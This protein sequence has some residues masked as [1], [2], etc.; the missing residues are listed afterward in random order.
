MRQKYQLITIK[1][2]SLAVFSLATM[3]PVF[4]ILPCGHIC[5][6]QYLLEFPIFRVLRHRTT[7]QE[8]GT[9]V[10]LVRR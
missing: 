3:I 4:L 8:H 10:N 2:Y 6:I 9:Q 1:L 7:V 5:F